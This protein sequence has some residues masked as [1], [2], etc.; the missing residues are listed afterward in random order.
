MRPRTPALA[1]PALVLLL[2]GP[3]RVDAQRGGGDGYLFGAPMITASIRGGLDRPLVNSGVFQFFTENLL[4]SQ[5]QF[6]AATWTG[7]IGIPIRDRLEISVSAGR[8]FS[9][10]PSESR[11]FIDNN[12]QPIRQTT[13]LSRT[14]VAVS[15]KYFITP[16]GEAISSLAW[17][18]NRFSPYVGVGV[19]QLWSRLE[20]QGDF[21]DFQTRDVFTDRFESEGRSVMTQVM[22]G[23][24]LRLSPRVALVG[25]ARY[26]WSRMPLDVD[27]VGFP[28]ADLSGISLTSGLTF[29]L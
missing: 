11:R 12:D 8:T 18:P 22:T 7:E 10:A 19:G 13:T 14:P 20:Q 4:L 2:G 16:R 17:I 29:R 1:I 23:A 5:R 15:A 21:V 26:L 24:E 9:S 25:E 3:V 27:F 28:K 6:M